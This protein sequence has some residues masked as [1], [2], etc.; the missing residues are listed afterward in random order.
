MGQAKTRY[1]WRKDKC[2]A[3]LISPPAMICQVRGVN[4]DSM[5]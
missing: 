3:L 5:G 2:S 1:G 4:L